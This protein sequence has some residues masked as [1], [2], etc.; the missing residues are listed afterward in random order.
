MIRKTANSDVRIKV[1][2]DGPYI[3]TGRVPLSEQIIV[4][5]S[6][7]DA[8]ALREGRRYPEQGTYSLCRCGKSRN[9]PFCDGSHIPEG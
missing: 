1:M 5:D 9:M 7:G 2:R 4:V 6:G 8:V 3:V